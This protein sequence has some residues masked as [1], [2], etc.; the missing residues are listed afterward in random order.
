[1]H[2]SNAAPPDP[3]LPARLVAAT[4][5]D[6]A[7]RHLEELQQIADTHGGNRAAGRPGFDASADNVAGGR[8]GST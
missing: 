3:G 4:T 2:S 5:G 8:R 6:G 1:M 7:Y